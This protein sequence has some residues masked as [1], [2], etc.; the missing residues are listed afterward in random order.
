MGAMAVAEGM[1]AGRTMRPI[2]ESW[3]AAPGFANGAAGLAS[4]KGKSADAR[5][6]YIEKSRKRGSSVRSKVDHTG[7]RP[8]ARRRVTQG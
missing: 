1:R 3:R 8:Q 6:A 2:T 4:R 5:R 7:C